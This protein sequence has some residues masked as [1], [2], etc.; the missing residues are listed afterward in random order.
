M[1]DWNMENVPSSGKCM[2]DLLGGV[3]SW[4]EQRPGSVVVVCR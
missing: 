2:L 1:D 4:R 3:S